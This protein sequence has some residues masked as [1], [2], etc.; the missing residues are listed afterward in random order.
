MKSNT[1]TVVASWDPRRR[2]TIHENDMKNKS[3]EKF[4]K[5]CRLRISISHLVWYV[6]TNLIDIFK[7]T[8]KSLEKIYPRGN[9]TRWSKFDKIL[10]FS[11]MITNEPGESPTTFLEFLPTYLTIMKH[12]GL[13]YEFPARKPGWRFTGRLQYSWL[14]FWDFCFVVWLMQTF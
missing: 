7:E 10:Q 2:A 6:P 3:F 13:C 9:F 11:K 1:G 12:C 14:L 8:Y 4:C 5:V